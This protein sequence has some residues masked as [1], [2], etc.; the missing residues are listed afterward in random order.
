MLLEK[1]LKF[2]LRDRD[3]KQQNLLD[4]FRSLQTFEQEVLALKRENDQMRMALSNHHE[5]EKFQSPS[6]REMSVQTVEM[7]APALGEETDEAVDLV[8]S[9]ALLEESIN[10]R[11]LD[12]A[13][14]HRGSKQWSSI[15][16][17]LFRV[18][19]ED[20]D[21]EWMLQEVSRKR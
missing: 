16:A 11:V 8:R 12:I 13:K 18:V 2:A 3:A 21:A 20:P 7:C 17:A 19:K 1:R 6:V 4:E 10:A 15:R 14:T 5:E 9:L